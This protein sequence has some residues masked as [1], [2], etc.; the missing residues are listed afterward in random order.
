[1]ETSSPTDSRHG[2]N[3]RRQASCPA[4]P[5]GNSAGAAQH[6]RP[7]DR[8]YGRLHWTLFAVIAAI[9]ACGLVVAR[10]VPMPRG[11]GFRM[12]LLLILAFNALWWTVADRRFA[13]YVRSPTWSRILR[14][15]ALAFSVALNV[16]IVY[17]LLAGR[18]ISFLESPT[19]YAAA[20]A[21]WHICLVVAMPLVAVLRLGGLAALYAIRTVRFHRECGLRS[22]QPSTV[23]HQLHKPVFARDTSLDPDRRAILRTAFATIPMTVLVGATAAA[24]AQEGRLLANRHTLPA[25][26][27][28]RRLAGLTITHISD[29][30]VGRHYRPYMLRRLVDKANALDSDVVVVTGD[31]VDTSNEMLPPVISA[32]S[33]LTHRH[34]LFICIG[35]H[36]QIDSRADFIRQVREHLPLLVNQ[37]RVLDIHGE[38]ITI[39]G[40]DFAHSDGRLGRRAGHCDNIAVVMRDYDP[41][42]HGPMIALSHH[43]HAFDP[44]ASAGVPLTLAGHTHGGQLMFTP[45]GERPDI[46]VGQLLFRYTRGFYRRGDK[47]LFVN[48]GVG[49]WF[50]L[51]IRAPTEIVQIRLT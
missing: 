41:Q 39:A 34:G 13:R 30:H 24:R 48:S 11:A 21:I 7:S 12:V 50:P 25:P 19:W 32:L 15:L 42:R 10:F 51:R 23:T 46:G 49:N 9:L 17:M 26:W 47:T 3:G 20:V 43:P 33:Q 35:N 31:L 1:M 38:R 36:D 22:H 29:L 45:P 40:L 37:R 6:R 5:C 27:L 2:R 14:L 44:L 28:P 18:S 8:T 4:Y 16:P